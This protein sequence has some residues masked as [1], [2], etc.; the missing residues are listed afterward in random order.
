M[1]SFDNGNCKS[2]FDTLVSNTIG[3]LSDAE[4]K[5]ILSTLDLSKKE[6]FAKDTQN[7][8]DRIM[9]TKDVKSEEPKKAEANE[10]AKDYKRNFKAKK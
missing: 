2:I 7:Q 9:K 1:I 5:K 3:D 4:A 10:S 8:I 6:S